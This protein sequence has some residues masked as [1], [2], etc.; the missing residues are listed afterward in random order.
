MV[1]DPAVPAELKT[2]VVVAL[3]R[4][5]TPTNEEALLRALASAE[6]S[7]VAAAAD[8]LARIG[9]RRAF[10]ALARERT[11]E[12]PGVARSVAFARTL[13]SY[14]LGLGEERLAGPSPGTLL[15]LDRERAVSVRLEEVGPDE[16]HAARPWLDRELPAVPLSP[17]GSLRFSCRNEHLWLVLARL[18]VSPGGSPVAE[19]DQVAAVL[20]KES[21]CPDGWFVND[22][23]HPLNDNAVSLFGVRSTGKLVHSGEIPTR[24]ANAAFVVRAV[25]V[26]GVAGLEFRAALGSDGALIIREALCGP[27][28]DERK[29]R[30]SSPRGPGAPPGRSV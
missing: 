7:V 5:A 22:L 27:P 19:K 16:F 15:E 20:L 17:K 26:P 24:A 8:G 4:E 6:P 12:R 13:I 14:R 29:S 30:P 21:A 11:G 2:T 25:D 1:S 23:T 10:D 9:G 18:S 3:G 28:R